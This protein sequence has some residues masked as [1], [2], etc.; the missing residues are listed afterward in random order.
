M[1]GVNKAG[2]PRIGFRT[3]TPLFS[4]LCTIIPITQRMLFKLYKEQSELMVD[5]IARALVQ[6]DS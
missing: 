5:L 2:E 4:E 6:E 3:T 1:K